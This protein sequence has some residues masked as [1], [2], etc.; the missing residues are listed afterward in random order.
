LFHQNPGLSE[1]AV[2]ELLRYTN[3]VQYGSIRYVRE[4]VDVHGVT[5]SPGSIM[6]ALLA[7]ANRDEAVFESPEQLDITR[8]PNRHLAFGLGS[9][10]CL[11]APL[12]R[13]EGQIGLR[14]LTQ[15]YPKLQLAVHPDQIRWSS[16][17]I[18]LR[19]V[20]ALPVRIA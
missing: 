6:V 14:T 8:H 13:L 20:K 1:P 19:G 15:C 4:A 2:E 7:A 11:G 5:L 3:P 10:Y 12:A 9:H 18:G 16:T 17:V